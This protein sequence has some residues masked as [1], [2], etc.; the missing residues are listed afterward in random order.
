MVHTL[1]HIGP[2]RTQYE[3]FKTS[4]DHVGMKVEISEMQI[5]GWSSTEASGLTSVCPWVGLETPEGGQ[6]PENPK[7]D[8]PRSRTQFTKQGKR[9]AREKQ[10]VALTVGARLTMGVV[11]D[12]RKHGSMDG[13]LGLT[14]ALCQALFKASVVDCS[15][16]TRTLWRKVLQPHHIQLGK[17]TK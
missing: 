9:G 13:P 15:T 11:L 10:G 2:D 7:E 14:L 1:D 4:S 12:Q 5:S 3:A 16:L 17:W 8:R 6:R